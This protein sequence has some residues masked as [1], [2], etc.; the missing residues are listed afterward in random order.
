MKTTKRIKLLLLILI[1]CLVNSCNNF[2][3]R[4]EQE[5][6]TESDKSILRFIRLYN[7]FIDAT[8]DWHKIS[9]YNVVTNVYQSND[10]VIYRFD[11]VGSGDISSLITDC[12]FCYIIDKHKIFSNNR[13]LSIKSLSIDSVLNVINP[14]QYLDYQKNKTPQPPELLWDTQGLKVVYVKNQLQLVKFVWGLE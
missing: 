14:K 1:I 11:A 10:T 7:S 13:L 12:R 8:I 9:D 5:P 2:K 3:T 4:N 6:Y